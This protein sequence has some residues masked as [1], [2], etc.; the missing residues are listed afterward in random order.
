VIGEGEAVGH[1]TVGPRK[2]FTEGGTGLGARGR[3]AADYGSGGLDDASV[4]LP[5]M[6]QSPDRKKKRKGERA[7][8]LVEDEQTWASGEAVNPDVVE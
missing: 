4:Y 6:S 2:A 3:A 5:S 8:Y 7:D 1:S